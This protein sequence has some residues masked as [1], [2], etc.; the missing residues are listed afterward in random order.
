MGAQTQLQQVSNQQPQQQPQQVAQISSTQQ[1]APPTLQVASQTL[2]KVQQVTAVQQVAPQTVQ[3]MLQPQQLAQPQAIAAAQTQQLHQL[4]PQPQQIHQQVHQL[5]Q[6]TVKQMTTQVQPGQQLGQLNLSVVSQQQL[7]GQA[8]VA[9]ASVSSSTPNAGASSSQVPIPNTV[10]PAGTNVVNLNLNQMRS[11][12]GAVQIRPQGGVNM[13]PGQMGLQGTII[14]TSSGNRILIQQPMLA[15]QQ[16]NLSQLGQP[17]LQSQTNQATSQQ[18]QAAS[19]NATLQLGAATTPVNTSGPGNI[20]I[21]PATKPNTASPNINVLNLNAA[22]PAVGAQQFVI[23]APGTNPAQ[24]QNIILRTFP[25]NIVQLQ[26][27]GGQAAAQPAQLGGQLFMAAQ[28]AQLQQ[29]HVV[30]APSIGQPQVLSNVMGNTPQGINIL[31]ATG[32]NNNNAQAA[33]NFQQLPGTIQAQNIQVQGQNVQVQGQTI[34]IIN[35]QGQ[36]IQLPKSMLGSSIKI[37]IGGQQVPINIG[38]IGQNWKM[39]QQAQLAGNTAPIQP[40]SLGV[41]TIQPQIVTASNNAVSTQT[42]TQPPQA[43]VLLASNSLTTVT[44]SISSSIPSPM[45][46]LGSQSPVMVMGSVSQVP[47]SM[48]G[49]TS[50]GIGMPLTLPAAGQPHSSIPQ[51]STSVAALPSISSTPQLQ[52]L[53]RHLPT[54]VAT[55]TPMQMPLGIPKVHNQNASRPIQSQPKPITIAS[56]GSNQMPT[57]NGT[58][59]ANIPT[60]V[61]GQSMNSSTPPPN[62]VVT[63]NHLSMAGIS[64]TNM[65]SI[66]NKAIKAGNMSMSMSTS[67]ASSKCAPSIQAPPNVTVQNVQLNPLATSLAGLTPQPLTSLQASSGVQ[68][69]PK[70]VVSMNQQ[71]LQTAT[72]VP[73]QGMLAT[74][75]DAKIPT[76]QLSPQ[77]QSILKQIQ[78]QIKILLNVANRS[79]KQQHFLQ[80]LGEAQQ[81]IIKQGQLTAMKTLQQRG[82][83]VGVSTSGNMSGMMTAIQSPAV[84]MASQSPA[85]IVASQN[86]TP[87]FTA[88]QSPAMVMTGQRS[89]GQRSVGQ[90]SVGIGTNQNHLVASQSPA[91]VVAGQTLYTNTNQPAAVHNQMA[92]I[93]QPATGL[94][95]QHAMRLPGQQTTGLISQQFT[96]LMGQ[97]ATGQVGQQ[98]PGL[99]GQQATGLGGQQPTGLGNK[100]ATGLG[101]QQ[102]AGLAGQLSTGLMG[103]Q[104]TGLLSPQATGLM[105]PQA[106]GLLSPQATGLGQL[107]T[108][109]VGQHATGLMSPQATDRLS[110]QVTGQ[111]VNSLPG[112]QAVSLPGQ[113]PVGQPGQRAMAHQ[114]QQTMSL[115]SQAKPVFTAQSTAVAT[116]QPGLPLRRPMASSSA[117]SQP[118][119]ITLQNFKPIPTAASATTTATH[120]QPTGK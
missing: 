95:N 46:S 52:H 93:G 96:G 45:V 98:V 83:V 78:Q 17:M 41:N 115:S 85:T 5:T 20:N 19:G 29:G 87:V 15:G 106:T 77:E 34:N 24:N 61:S 28:P 112:Q 108:D 16:F 6:Q 22:T 86:T 81:K 1:G 101:G 67:V 50:S 9:L 48:S 65:T 13:L 94:P 84:V 88:S 38:N 79:D 58:S 7:Q 18:T 11:L 80:K 39:L 8:G 59:K 14:Q 71:V 120:T 102:A 113:L 92:M 23:R 30:G 105:S 75:Q 63:Q 74:S 54:P 82:A 118:G 21:Q 12:A 62:V 66:S 114:G 68:I 2:Q 31:P 119:I 99:M 47:S 43:G 60:F 35:S 104:A 36:H 64:T 97:Q 89:A 73:A 3:Q 110:Q 76:I 40:T 116:G 103:Q 111:S 57:V 56:I 117:S 37:N 10:L 72:A 32:N 70:P 33:Q 27:G 90:S 100:Q 49:M 55:S 53:V 109:L 4:A 44:N 26:G 69:M 42:L 51:P 25:S 107:A 91:S